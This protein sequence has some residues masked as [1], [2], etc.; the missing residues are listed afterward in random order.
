MLYPTKS[1]VLNSFSNL[2]PLVT[3][4]FEISMGVA[5]CS[6]CCL[7]QFFP[8]VVNHKSGPNFIA[9]HKVCAPSES[10][11]VFRSA[12]LASYNTSA[13]VLAG[14]THVE[15]ETKLLLVCVKSL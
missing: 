13:V 10:G 2:E 14:S 15:S 5:V 6:A 7:V 1:F 8:L 11:N 9:A 12:V 3:C 4:H